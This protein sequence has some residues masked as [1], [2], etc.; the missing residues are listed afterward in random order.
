MIGNQYPLNQCIHAIGEC[1]AVLS[2]GTVN[3]PKMLKQHQLPILFQPVQQLIP[4]I[5]LQYIGDLLDV[6]LRNCPRWFN[7]LEVIE[8]VSMLHQQLL[9]VPLGRLNQLSL[10]VVVDLLAVMLRQSFEAFATHK[11]D[12]NFRELLAR[13]YVAGFLQQLLELLL[14]SVRAEACGKRTGRK[15]DISN[16]GWCI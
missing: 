1:R 8:Q 15:M 9:E 14:P 2:N 16:R 12:P 7:V 10:V 11:E 5:L 13:G 4:Q 3:E 6:V